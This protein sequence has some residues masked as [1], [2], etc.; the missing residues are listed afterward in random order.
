MKGRTEL[1]NTWVPTLIDTLKALHA[2]GVCHGDIRPSNLMLHPTTGAIY[3]TDFGLAKHFQDFD[4]E[5][6]EGRQQDYDDLAY[7]LYCLECDAHHENR[8]C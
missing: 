4:Q 8:P 2:R 3:L 5:Y 6:A 1:L 7:T